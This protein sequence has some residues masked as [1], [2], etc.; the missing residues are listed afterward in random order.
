MWEGTHTGPHANTFTHSH[1]TQFTPA[2]SPAG[3]VLGGGGWPEKTHV[4]TERT[5]NRNFMHTLTGDPVYVLWSKTN[6]PN[7]LFFLTKNFFCFFLLFLTM[8]WDI[9]LVTL[10]LSKSLLRCVFFCS[11]CYLWGFPDSSTCIK[12]ALIPCPCL[13]WPLWRDAFWSCEARA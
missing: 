1:Q 2:N 6:E 4:N 12:C 5:W 11:G 7:R 8:N 9:Y 10:Q 13:L 3:M